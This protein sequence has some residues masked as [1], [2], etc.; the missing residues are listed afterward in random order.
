[1]RPPRPPHPQPKPSPGVSR[2]RLLWKHSRGWKP[3]AHP[4]DLT[5]TAVL[6]TFAPSVFVFV[7]TSGLH[8]CPGYNLLP[9]TRNKKQ[10]KT[11]LSYVLWSKLTW[12][13]QEQFIILACHRNPQ[14]AGSWAAVPA[15]DGVQC[16]TCISCLKSKRKTYIWILKHIGSSAF[17]MWPWAPNPPADLSWGHLPASGLR[18]GDRDRHHIYNRERAKIAFSSTPSVL[19]GE[20]KTQAGSQD[21]PSHVWISQSLNLKIWQL[22]NKGRC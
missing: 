17:C 15:L 4:P 1:M 20:P 5:P 14:W 12:R 21:K 2:P 13:E 9:P 7:M 22:L 8:G 6:T 10:G 16:N 3:S 19:N 11:R 18:W